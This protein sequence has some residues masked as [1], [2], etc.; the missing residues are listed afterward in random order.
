MFGWLNGLVGD[1]PLTYLIVAVLAV[2][3]IT[4]VVPAETVVVTAVVLAMKGQL[5]IVGIAVAGFVGAAAGDNLLYVLGNSFG[6][7]VIGWIFRG[8]A[9]RERLDW[10]RRRMRQHRILIIIAGRFIPMGR[11]AVMFAAGALEVP[12]RRFIGPELVAVTIWTGYWV[13]FTAIAGEAL[14]GKSWLTILISLGIGTV[15]G[16]IAEVIR[17]YMERR[18]S[19]DRGSQR[20]AQRG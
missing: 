8:R 1:T 13:G 4:G 18:R 6:E 14:S 15:I 9:S 5:F 16:L 20:G 10:A 3:D 12:W 19:G 11:T 2:A 7:R 17:R